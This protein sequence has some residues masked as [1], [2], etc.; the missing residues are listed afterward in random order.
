MGALVAEVSGSAPGVVGEVD[1]CYCAEAGAGV[2]GE[3]VE[4]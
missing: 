2:S 4:G 1:V 3:G